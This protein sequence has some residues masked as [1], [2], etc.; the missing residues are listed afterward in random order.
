MAEETVEA[1]AARLITP[2][3]RKEHIIAS[4]APGSGVHVRFRFNPGHCFERCALIYR[5]PKPGNLTV[6]LTQRYSPAG[7]VT[8]LASRTLPASPRPRDLAASLQYLAA[9]GNDWESRP[10]WRQITGRR[11]PGWEARIPMTGDAAVDEAR[12]LVTERAASE[13]TAQFLRGEDGDLVCASDP[14]PHDMICSVNPGGEWSWHLDNLTVPVEIAPAS[15]LSPYPRSGAVRLAAQDLG[16]GTG[17]TGRSA[18]PEAR[19]AAQPA[20][21]RPARRR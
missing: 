18:E 9:F 7:P 14:T 11:D 12:R 17:I 6:V 8:W 15:E 10:H 1:A 13:G 16:A 19:P 4:V 3:I 21:A 20:P 5:Q 2:E